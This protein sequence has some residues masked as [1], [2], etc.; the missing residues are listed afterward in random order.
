MV[1]IWFKIFHNILS[2]SIVDGD[3]SQWSPWSDCSDPCG[4]YKSRARQCDSPVPTGGGKLCEGKNTETVT[5]SG[6]CPGEKT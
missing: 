6:E 2:I 3:W 5:C 1:M 4:G